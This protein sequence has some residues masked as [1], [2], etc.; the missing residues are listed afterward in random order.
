MVVCQ[1]PVP[2]E[3]E[4]GFFMLLIVTGLANGIRVDTNV[5]D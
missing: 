3:E 1:Q 5:L 4:A 2:V